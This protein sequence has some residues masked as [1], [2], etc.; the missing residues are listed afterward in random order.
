MES[1]CSNVRRALARRITISFFATRPPRWHQQAERTPTRLDWRWRSALPSTPI[2]TSPPSVAFDTFRPTQCVTMKQRSLGFFLIETRRKPCCTLKREKLEQLRSIR[3]ALARAFAND[4]IRFQS[5]I[6]QVVSRWACV[7]YTTRSDDQDRKT[8]EK[9]AKCTA[10]YRRARSCT[11][12]DQSR[13]GE[14]K[15]NKRGCRGC[16]EICARVSVVIILLL[17]KGDICSFDKEKKND[18]ARCPL[19]TGDFEIPVEGG[20]EEKNPIVS[21]F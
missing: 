19:P 4:S 1:E 9:R 6:V 18:N 16:G 5:V 2:A 21:Q 8:R 17:S 14:R 12:E 13:R 20:A 15:D 10:F 7:A 11:S 3:Y